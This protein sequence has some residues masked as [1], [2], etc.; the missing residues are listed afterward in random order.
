MS[1]TVTIVSYHREENT[2]GRTMEERLFFVNMTQEV[3]K[4]GQL[5]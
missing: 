2:V 5:D 1:Q 3:E 4:Q